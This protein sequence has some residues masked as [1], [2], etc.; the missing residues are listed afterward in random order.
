MRERASACWEARHNQNIRFGDYSRSFL[1]AP[2]VVA[3]V[4]AAHIHP[5][6]AG[7]RAVELAEQGADAIHEL[8][9]A[10]V[11]L[12]FMPLLGGG[13]H[14]AAARGPTSTSGPRAPS[15]IT[16]STIMIVVQM[17]RIQPSVWRAALAPIASG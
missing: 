14:R 1:N 7:R 13:R 9:T 17:V 6:T 8:R 10:S 4:Q 16:A 3:A 5:S 11:H 12:I 15:T 2:A